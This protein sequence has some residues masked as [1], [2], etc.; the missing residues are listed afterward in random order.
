MTGPPTV[1]I[2]VDN[3]LTRTSCPLSPV[4]QH[5]SRKYQHPPTNIFDMAPHTP[6]VLRFE[7]LSK[8]SNPAKGY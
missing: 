7:K 2:H 3:R 8:T 4:F 6:G 1:D 5:F